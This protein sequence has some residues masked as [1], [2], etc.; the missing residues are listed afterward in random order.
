MNEKEEYPIGRNDGLPSDKQGN[1]WTDSNEQ[2]Q[3]KSDCSADAAAE[4]AETPN[5]TEPP[6]DRPRSPLRRR[7][8]VRAQPSSPP[9][10]SKQPTALTEAEPN[11]S[12]THT[13][14]QDA[15][16]THP[17]KVH[18]ARGITILIAVCLTLALLVSA[19]AM[20]LS[21][22]LMSLSPTLPSDSS[23]EAEPTAPDTEGSRIVF[24]RQYDDQ[25]GLLT[26]A[27]L[28]ETCA[29]TVVSILADS[30][31]SSAVGSGF[32]LS[33]DGYIATAHHV[34]AS[35]D[36]VTVA[37][38][39][40]TRYAATKVSGDAMSD[41]AVLKIEE[42]ELPFAEFGSSAELLTG[43]AVIAIGTAASA[44]YAGTLCSGEI[45]CCT[46]TVKLYEEATGAV[47]KKMKL[48]QANLTVRPGNVGCPLWNEYGQVVGMV[49]EAVGTDCP[50]SGFAIPSDAARP[51]LQAMMQGQTPTDAMIAAVAT[52]TPHLGILGQQ[53]ITD[54][55]CGVE[56][57]GFSDLESSAATV[58]RKGDIILRIGE[59]TIC[60]N[61][62]IKAAIAEKNAGDRVPITI[63][64]AEQALT[65]DIILEKQ[66]NN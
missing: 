30:R 24:I 38:A 13:D 26:K 51:I 58:L 44:D 17:P 21:R 48:I 39:D 19:G 4:A 10:H 29:D 16:V 6:A 35:M 22:K 3:E 12:R 65:F 41:L 61:A 23:S 37:L 5:V 56:V 55:V 63:L 60:A 9:T 11:Q 45:A 20:A 62:D 14:P 2:E 33:S 36:A 47:T 28:Y 18:K 31:S 40:G 66:K 57:V 50:D 32:L 49:T 53:V 15:S 52:L 8:P 64:R 59:Q 1:D 27:E 34:V 54:H 42:T 25:S 7:L 43:D 46:R